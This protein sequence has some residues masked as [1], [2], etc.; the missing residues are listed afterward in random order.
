MTLY[1]RW[2]ETARVNRQGLACARPLVTGATCVVS[3]LLGVLSLGQAMV[4]AY[5]QEAPAISAEEAVPLPPRKPPR[6]PAPL[7]TPPGTAA[8]MAR[9]AHPRPPALPEPPAL[10]TAPVIPSPSALSTAAIAV[11]FLP[12]PPQGAAPP[13]PLAPTTNGEGEPLPDGFRA[14]LS[15]PPGSEEL[16]EQS[17]EMLTGLGQRLRATKG[18]RLELLAFASGEDSGAMHRLA[19][20]RA[21][22]VRTFL[23]GRGIPATKFVVRPQGSAA[24]RQIVAGSAGKRDI[25]ASQNS[26]TDDDHIELRIIK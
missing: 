13:A 9:L 2:Q 26:N 14:S 1:D 5:G 15:F 20:Q 12:Q 10:P 16:T 22:A 11:P 4:P 8:N 17:R 19:L 3:L 21:I 18:R 24:E 23:V 6:R 25:P 7:A